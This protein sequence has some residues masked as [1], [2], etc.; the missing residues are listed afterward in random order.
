MD[1]CAACERDLPRIR[2]ACRRCALPLPAP[3]VC[4]AC[5]RVPSPLQEVHAPF[6]YAAPLDRLLPRFK[7]HDDLAAGRLLAQLMSE[8]FAAL[9]K[10]D[11]LVPV[12]LHTGRLRSRGYDQALE[13]ARPLARALDIPLRTRWLVRRRATAPQSERDAM[14]RRRNVRNAFVVRESACVPPHVVLIDDVMTTGATLRA[15]AHALRRAGALRVD[16]WVCAR[17][18]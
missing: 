8:A 3:G 11:A 14:S 16:A 15:A 2:A 4:G 7:F 18:P 17:T 10:P 9:Q 6:A 5:L 13:L 1:L 12:P